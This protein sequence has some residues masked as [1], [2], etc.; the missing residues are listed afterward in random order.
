MTTTEIASSKELYEEVYVRDRQEREAIFLRDLSRDGGCRIR[1]VI[2]ETTHP[3][4]FTVRSS[5]IASPQTLEL[6]DPQSNTMHTVLAVPS[7]EYP[8]SLVTISAALRQLFS[9]V[10]N[11]TEEPVSSIDLD[12]ALSS[13]NGAPQQNVIDYSEKF[14]SLLYGY[15]EH[16]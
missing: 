15:R 16:A 11:A 10:L 4:D 12:V 14:L 6:K 7:K 13:S 8:V 9:K 3:L 5:F 2:D 1:C